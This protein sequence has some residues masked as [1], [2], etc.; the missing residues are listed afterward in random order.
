MGLGP[1]P[2]IGSE[3]RRHPV[4]APQWRWRIDFPQKSRC[5]AA[6]DTS[7]L[8]Q[9]GHRTGITRAVLIGWQ[10]LTPSSWGLDNRRSEQYGTRH[11][12]R[13]PADHRITSGSLGFSSVPCS[14][15]YCFASGKR[16]SSVALLEPLEMGLDCRGALQIWKLLLLAMNFSMSGAAAAR[17]SS[18]QPLG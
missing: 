5:I 10:S 1:V 16:K 14:D 8:D 13:T 11:E 2:C 18:I 6:I 9:S 17:S 7:S 4:R 3:P 12:T 15:T